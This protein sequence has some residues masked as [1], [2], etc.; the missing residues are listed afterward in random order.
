MNYTESESPQRYYG[1][2]DAALRPYC[3]D[4][5]YSEEQLEFIRYGIENNVDVS[6][7]ANPNMRADDMRKILGELLA[8]RNI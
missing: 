8:K 2:Q 4:L 1:L 6:V 3:E 5:R 7:Y